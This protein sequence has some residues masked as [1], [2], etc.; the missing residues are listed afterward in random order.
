LKT[1]TKNAAPAIANSVPAPRGR[2][3]SKPPKPSTIQMIGRGYQRE[4]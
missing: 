2:R 3:R 4:A 1:I